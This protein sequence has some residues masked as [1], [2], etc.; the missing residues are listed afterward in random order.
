MIP[1]STIEKFRESLRGQSFCPKEQGYW[2]F[3]HVS[4][5]LV[6]AWRQDCLSPRRQ[7]FQ[8]FTQGI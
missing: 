8:T 3:G 2:K 7:A 6:G 1:Q 5:R 4:G